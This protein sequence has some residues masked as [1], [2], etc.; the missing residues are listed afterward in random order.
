MVARV[1]R[2][3]F[4]DNIRIVA[5]FMVV[6][7]HALGYCLIL[8]QAYFSVI[9]FAV[10]AV[11]V[12][13]FFLV[14]GYLFV[15]KKKDNQE[16]AYGNHIKKSFFRLI[17]PWLIFTIFYTVIRYV[18]ECV[19]FLNEKQIIGHSLND[20]IISSY[21]SVYAPQ[22]YFLASLF[23]IR[24]LF[25]LTRLLME[26]DR[27]YMLLVYFLYVIVYYAMIK[28]QIASYLEISGGQEPII[29]AFWGLQFY[30]FG[31]VMKLFEKSIL[32]KPFVLGI[33]AFLLMI[34]CK[35]I[36]D[37]KYSG[38]IAQYMYLFWIFVLFI[39]Y[40]KSN[41]LFRSIGRNTIG[42]YL[43]H[44]PVLLK[45]V[46]IVINSL[47]VKPLLSYFYITSLVFVISYVV[48]IIVNNLPYGSLLFGVPYRREKTLFSSG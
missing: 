27:Y 43:I 15:H 24:L 37:M 32:S 41:F 42:I 12:P 44:A 7:V 19:N 3:D 45:C 6:A 34:L 48:A 46:S 21:G 23:F 25:P 29:H 39:S 47:T 36:L 38:L 2:L 1:N 30:L 9:R 4:L 33:F 28:G 11:A 40:P 35:F 16:L 14:D 31:I 20:V 26:V 18:F 22:L 13:I 8:P 17:I 5:I 10:Q